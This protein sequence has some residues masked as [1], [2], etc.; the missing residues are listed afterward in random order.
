MLD[1]LPQHQHRIMQKYDAEAVFGAVT[2]VDA[3]CDAGADASSDDGADAGPEA[4]ARG[5][6]GLD[7]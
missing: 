3:G 6:V 2:G 5:A 1:T 7:V 4:S